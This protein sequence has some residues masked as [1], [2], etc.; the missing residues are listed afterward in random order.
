MEQFRAAC[1]EAGLSL[2]HQ[3]EV[4][5]R[6]LIEMEGHPNPELIYERVKSQVP[7]I[8]LGT[9]YKNLNMF[10]ERGLAK[11]VTL[12]HGSL[13]LET[14]FEPHHHLVCIRCKEIVD[15]DDASVEPVRLS[16]GLPEGFSLQRYTVEFQGTCGQCAGAA[17]QT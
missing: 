16:A 5:F 8:S 12:H 15:L 14:N 9:V 17:T 1:R 3:R 6:A 7:A 11:E 13:R 4:I 2:T 10:L